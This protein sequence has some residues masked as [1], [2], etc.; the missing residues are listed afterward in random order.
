MNQAHP[1]PQVDHVARDFMLTVALNFARHTFLRIEGALDRSPPGQVATTWDF[2]QTYLR[3]NERDL[4]VEVATYMR[5]IDATAEET[6][7]TQ[8]A[9]SAEYRRS[10]DELSI[11]ARQG[12]VA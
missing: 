7:A 8:V 5:A 2:L 11:W 3:H 10:L 6:Q 12:G 9:A 4:A 1:T